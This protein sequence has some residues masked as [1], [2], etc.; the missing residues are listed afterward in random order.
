MQSKILGILK[1]KI[2]KIDFANFATYGGSV[3]FSSK[4]SEA[5]ETKKQEENI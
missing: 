3:L 5:G 2:K 4:R 1:Y